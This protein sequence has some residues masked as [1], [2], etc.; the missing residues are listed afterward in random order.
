MVI[1]FTF[2]VRPVFIVKL[3]AILDGLLLTPLQALWVGIGLYFVIPKLFNKEVADILKPH[4]IFAAGLLIAFFVFGYFC[5][6]Q[7][8]YSF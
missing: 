7:I 8:P 6:F 3:A 2:D 4:W 5:I 1:V